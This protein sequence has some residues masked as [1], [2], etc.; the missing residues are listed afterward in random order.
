M[1]VGRFTTMCRFLLFFL[2]VLCVLSLPLFQYLY[3]TSDTDLHFVS[4][5]Y[6]FVCAI[7]ISVQQVCPPPAHA[8]NSIVGARMAD[9]GVTLQSYKGLLKS[10][11]VLLL[12]SFIKMTLHSGLTDFP[13]H[14]KSQ[15][16]L[17]ND[18]HRSRFHKM[19]SPFFCHPSVT[20]T[21]VA[22]LPSNPPALPLTAQ[23]TY[24]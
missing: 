21:P 4:L 2:I 20:T 5:L 14:L 7:T 12:Q 19:W 10:C 1:D 8:N 13:S 16:K 9:S 23:F 22:T 3:Q 11:L 18:M 6:L 15:S 17:R 24:L